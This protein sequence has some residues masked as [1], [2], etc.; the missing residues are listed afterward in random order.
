[1]RSSRKW[2][3]VL[4]A[5]VDDIRVCRSY[6]LPFEDSSIDL[7]YCF[8]SAHHFVRHRRTL[9][10]IHRVLKAGGRALYIHEPVC[11]AYIHSLAHRRVNRKRPAVPEDVLIYPR[12]IGLA[13][14]AGFK[15]GIALLPSIQNRGEKET[16]YYLFLKMIPGLE[17]LVP[18]T[19]D[20]VF[21]KP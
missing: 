6:E 3:R 21:E 4:E 16:I 5:R 17:R 10:E 8:Q 20:F 12:I 14:Q 1:M 13:R 19:G 11:R 7:V 2:E 9:R 18:C 15:A